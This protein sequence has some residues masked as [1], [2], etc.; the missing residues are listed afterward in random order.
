[1]T[2]IPGTVVLCDTCFERRTGRTAQC[3]DGCALALDH[4][5]VCSPHGWD[6]CDECGTDDRLHLVDG[7][8]PYEHS[9]ATEDAR[10]ASISPD[11]EAPGERDTRECLHCGYPV[12]HGSGAA[13]GACDVCGS[14]CCEDHYLRYPAYAQH[15][16]AADRSEVPTA[17]TSRDPGDALDAI[18]HMLRDPEPAAAMLEDIGAIVTETGRSIDNLPGGEPTWDR[19]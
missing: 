9:R 2:A 12:V 16:I 1:M 3:E 15:D 13:G 4:T 14:F 10:N 6:G 7:A 5:G 17:S 18:A 19:H 8:E 11:D